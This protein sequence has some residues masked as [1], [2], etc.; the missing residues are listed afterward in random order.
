MSQCFSLRLDVV[1]G[2][3]E[4]VLAWLPKACSSWIVAYE[5]DGDNPHVHMILKTELNDKKLRHSVVRAFGVKGNSGYSLKA[6]Y[7]DVS[8]YIR[9]ICK[10]SSKDEPPQIWS[11]QG[12]D[13]TE[14]V[15]EEAHEMYWV[16]NAAIKENGA[17]RK[18]LSKLN[19]VEEVEKVCKE[20]GVK[21][22]DRVEVARVYISKYVD[23][24]RAINVYAAK[25]VV[26]TVCVL[27]DP[28]GAEETNLAQK[29][30]EL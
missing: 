23:A 2:T 5:N 18:R 4:K 15:I 20:K 7:D 29:C 16:N 27:L 14:A 9:Y 12:L 10:G 19:V 25:A 6:C 13:Y 22:Y 26:N 28:T 1:D 3:K 30:A 24:R 11:R 8:G 17:K 21:S